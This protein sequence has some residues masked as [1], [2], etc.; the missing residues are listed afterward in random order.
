MTIIIG[1]LL[2]FTGIKNSKAYYYGPPAGATNSPFDG[3]SCAYPGCHSTHPLQSPKPWISSNVPP[4][5]Y[6]PDT[7]Y[8]FTAKA[9]YIGKT[10][11]GFEISPQT[12][13]GSPLGTLIV[14]NA[15]TTQITTFSGLQYIEQTQN[16]YVG[17]DSVV[18]SFKWKAPIR[19]TGSVTFYGCFNCGQGNSSSANTYVYPATL[20]IP[21]N[22]LAGIS[23]LE[24]ESTAFSVFPNPVKEQANISYNLKKTTNV[25]INLYGIDGRKICALLNTM[26][27]EGEHTQ[28]LSIPAGTARGIYLIQLTT[29]GQSTTQRII[30]E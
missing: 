18:W 26:V 5:G 8:T 10:S 30:I 13:S 21:E 14:S 1:G 29:N 23:N 22:T 17:T 20:V 6:S 11:F 27:N 25:Q 2:Y 15:T 9:V 3:A 24:S 4:A 16:G 28:S 19:G 12:V 7:I